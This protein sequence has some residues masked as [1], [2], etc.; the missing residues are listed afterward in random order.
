M[1]SNHPFVSFHSH[2]T[3]PMKLISVF[4]VLAIVGSA[5]AATTPATCEGKIPK[6]TVDKC[7]NEPCTFEH[8]G[9]PSDPYGS[10]GKL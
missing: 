4:G 10:T 7:N 5:F 3:I 6:F 1:I 8:R 2:P 9:P